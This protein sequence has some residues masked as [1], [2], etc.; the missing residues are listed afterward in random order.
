MMHVDSCE[1]SKSELDLFTM[2]PTMTAMESG[3]YIQYGPMSTIS[4]TGPIEFLVEAN[5]QFLDIN[6]TAL[7]IKAKIVIA[8]D[9]SDPADEDPATQVMAPVNLW[10]HALFSQVDVTLGS[11]RITSST[12]MYPYRAYIETLLNFDDAAK[13]NKLANE[14]YY[15]E[16]NGGKDIAEAWCEDKIER[17]KAGQTIDMV[18]RLHTD[19]FHQNRYLLP[20][21]VLKL[22]LTR[23]KSD[24]NMMVKKGG[25]F[26][27]IIESARLYVR[28]VEVS[29]SEIN[30]I[31]TKLNTDNARY[32]I[33]RVLVNNFNIPA[34]MRTYTKD[35][36][37][38][39]GNQIP[40]RLILAMV[41]ND[42]FR[43]DLKQNPFNFEHFGINKLEIFANGRSI[44]GQPLE[45]DFENKH[46]GRAY[47]QMHQA[48]GKGFGTTEDL[49]IDLDEYCDGKTL[50]VFDL[51]PDQGANAAHRHLAHSGSL[52]VDMSFTNANE[53]PITVILFGEFD[54]TI[55]VTKTRDTVLDY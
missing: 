32:P 10:F 55:E 25:P 12:D 42:A 45:P 20:K 38:I 16:E 37:Y 31:E 7:Q 54:N 33:R 14:M 48:L 41:R 49:G 26:K 29:A 22:S 11:D 9:G 5:D 46:V 24:F 13:E 17:I 52:R 30:V 6:D 23:S 3:K 27:V 15:E 2:P 34:G 50:F 1:C 51:T 28:H 47:H 21:T 40:K 19:L 8:K 53:E 4:D 39:G 44:L 18:G 36:L 35:N 43:G